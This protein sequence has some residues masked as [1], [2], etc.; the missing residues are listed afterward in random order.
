[1]YRTRGRHH[2]SAAVADPG[3]RRSARAHR[4]RLQG[5]P[6]RATPRVDGDELHPLHLRVGQGRADLRWQAAIGGNQL[7]LSTRP[8]R[9]QRVRASAAPAAMRGRPAR[10][11]MT[12]DRRHEQLRHR[13]HRA[14]R[15]VMPGCGAVGSA[16]AAPGAALAPPGSVHAPRMDD[17][18]DVN[19]ASWDERAAA[20]AAS[21]DYAVAASPTTP[22]S[23]ARS[24]ASI[25][26]GSATSRAST[27]VHLQCHIGTDTVSLARLGARDDGPRLLAAG[28][29]AG[30]ASRRGDR[31]RGRVRESDLYEAVDALGARRFD[32]VFTG[33]GALCW[34]PD[35]KRWAEVV[36]ALLRPGGRLFIREGHPVLWSLS[37][38]RPDGLLVLEYPY[39]ERAEPTVWDEGGTYVETDARVHADRHARVEPRP[40]RD[41]H[42]G[43]RRR[44]WS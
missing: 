25:S 17:Y 28:A 4:P 33:I 34:L 43:A 26:R 16:R 15:E 36:A 23:S 2:C 13:R 11:E 5:H 24:C 35:V 10:V 14:S 32:L 20:H 37:D 9:R 6:R 31:R 22:R 18:R 21:P 8:R 12:A 30:P 19:R 42:R 38:P 27:R 29:R 39:F 3:G 7:L 41:H 44:A 1:M 40:R